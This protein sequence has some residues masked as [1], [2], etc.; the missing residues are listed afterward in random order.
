MKCE[1]LAAW[2]YREESAALVLQAVFFLPPGCGAEILAPLAEEKNFRNFQKFFEKCL[3]INW[4]MHLEMKNTVFW[5]L[6]RAKNSFSGQ[7]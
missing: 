2:H 4:K 7:I 5:R 6:R 3:E 1:R